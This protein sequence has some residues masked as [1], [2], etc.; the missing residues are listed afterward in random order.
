[1]GGFVPMKMSTTNPHSI[2]V[3]GIIIYNYVKLSESFI[4]INLY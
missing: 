2:Y 1:M 4:Y 3:H